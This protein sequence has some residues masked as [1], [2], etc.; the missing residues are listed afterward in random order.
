MKKII[1]LAILVI[2]L[3]ACELLDPNEWEKTRQ[4]MKESGHV[5]EEDYKGYY[6]C[7]DTK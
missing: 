1:I 2:T 4:N 6:H 7:Y 5:C 3:T